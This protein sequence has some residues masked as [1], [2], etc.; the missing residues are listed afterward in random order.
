[1]GPVQR[2]D[3]AAYSLPGIYL[4]SLAL[5][6]IHRLYTS[7]IVQNPEKRTHKESWLTDLSPTALFSLAA[8]P[9]TRAASL[10]VLSLVY[11]GCGIRVGT[12]WVLGGAIPV[13][14]RPVPG[15]DI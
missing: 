7:V 12:G 4:W 6:A 11:P 10:A 8:H 15:P 9:C 3:S 2:L 14:T 5:P 13:P 1:M